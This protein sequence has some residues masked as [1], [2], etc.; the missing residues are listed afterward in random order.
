M[1]RWPHFGPP[2]T[3]PHR[4]REREGEREEGEVAVG[5]GLRKH[6]RWGG[7]WER[8]ETEYCSE[9]FEPLDRKSDGR[10]LMMTWPTKE[11]KVVY[12]NKVYGR[13]VDVIWLPIWVDITCLVCLWNWCM[14]PSSSSCIH[15]AKS[16]IEAQIERIPSSCIR[17]C[18]QL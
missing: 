17:P 18:K 7:G 10:H 4:E 8:G 16:E 2:A 14:G 12:E 15:L 5:H 9:R 13:Y 11:P 1:Q 6:R 3:L